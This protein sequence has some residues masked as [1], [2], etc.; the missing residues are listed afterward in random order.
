MLTKLKPMEHKLILPYLTFC[1][2]F[3]NS[4]VGNG[5]SNDGEDGLN[6]VEMKSEVGQPVALVEA[7]DQLAE[8]VQSPA[9]Q[10]DNT[11]LPEE[12]EPIAAGEEDSNA[13]KTELSAGLPNAEQVE[14]TTTATTEL[15]TIGT[16]ATTPEYG[17]PAQSDE[18]EDKP[19]GS[20]SEHPEHAFIIREP[21]KE[22]KFTTMEDNFTEIPSTTVPVTDSNEVEEGVEDKDTATLT[23]EAG[24]TGGSLDFDTTTELNVLENQQ[25]NAEDESQAQQSD[26]E[27]IQPDE[28]AQ[29]PAEGLVEIYPEHVHSDQ[30]EGEQDNQVVTN[31]PNT[32]QQGDQETTNPG[33]TEQVS[34]TESG[35]ATEQ[36]AKAQEV[37]ERVEMAEFQ[38]SENHQHDETDADTDEQVEA[39][40]LQDAGLSSQQP[41]DKL[42][43][44]SSLPPVLEKTEDPHKGL[45]AESLILEHGGSIHGGLAGTMQQEDPQPVEAVASNELDINDHNVADEVED[46]A[47]QEAQEQEGGNAD[48]QT[49]A[50]PQM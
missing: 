7:I 18:V 31:E 30:P 36:D 28:E 40:Q 17:T 22:P 47:V 16:E 25:D 15:T 38:L 44:L 32:E 14:S 5:Q 46:Q 2:V 26:D 35:Y 27:V 10:Q 37:P 11:I 24:T 41:L 48:A 39:A 6:S 9:S 50:D 23:T 1:S 33:I 49:N 43:D 4:D 8:H 29:F 45:V 34:T 19:V 12:I 20:I 3:F 42:D 13:D 21:A